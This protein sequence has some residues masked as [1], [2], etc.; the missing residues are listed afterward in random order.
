MLRDK[1]CCCVNSLLRRQLAGLTVICR[2][3]DDNAKRELS[4][5][6]YWQLV[7]TEGKGQQAIQKDEKLTQN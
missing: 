5:T 6:L 3:G 7:Y 4:L 2:W 1:C